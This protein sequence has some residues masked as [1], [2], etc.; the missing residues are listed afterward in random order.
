MKLLTQGYPAAPWKE[1]KNKVGLALLDGI[2]SLHILLSFKDVSKM[3]LSSDSSGVP[4]AD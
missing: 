4:E 1:R 3:I 2:M